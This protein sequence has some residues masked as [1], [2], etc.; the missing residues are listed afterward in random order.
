MKKVNISQYKQEK[1]WGTDDSLTSAFNRKAQK[2]L[3]LHVKIMKRDLHQPANTL[4][5]SDSQSAGCLPSSQ[6]VLLQLLHTPQ[7]FRHAQ[8]P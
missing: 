8:P 6:S 5:D 7:P 4:S 1:S 3:W 2:R